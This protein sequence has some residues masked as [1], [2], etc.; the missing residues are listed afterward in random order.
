MMYKPIINQIPY[1]E[2]CAVQGQL[3][4]PNMSY[5]ERLSK[6]QVFRFL[7]TKRNHHHA[8][9]VRAKISDLTI[10]I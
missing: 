2:L 4:T 1:Q 9:S 10:N 3:I 8:L 5:F 6:F 7:Q